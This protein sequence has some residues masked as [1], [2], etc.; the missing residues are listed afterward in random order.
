MNILFISKDLTG[1]DLAYRLK[2]EGHLVRLFIED[3]NQKQNLEGIVDKTN[4]WKKELKWVGKNGLIIFDSIGYGKTQDDL[5]KDGYSVLGGNQKSDQIE[6]D[7]QYGQKILSA[8]GISL[9]PSI[10]FS[11]VKEAIKFLKK[12]KGRWV[13]KQN[14]HVHKGF[15]YVGEMEDGSDT[16]EILKNYAK[17]NKKECSNIDLQKRVDGVEIGVARYFNGNDWVGPIEINME[18]KN[19]CNEDIGPKTDEMGTLMWYENNEKNKLFQK[20]LAKLKPYLQSINFKGDFDIDLIVNEDKIYPL[21]VTARLGW[22]AIQLQSEIHDSPWGE[23]L[24]AVADGK[25]YNLRY[26]KGF[27][28]VFLVATP[29][30]PYSEKLKKYS[31]Y[32]Q[33]IFFKNNFKKDDLKHIHLEEISVKKSRNNKEYYYISSRSGCILTVTSLG[34]TVSEARKKAYG[35][36]SK[37]VIPKAIYRTDIGLKFI[38]EHQNK[39]KK[40]GWI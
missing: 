17:N 40:W 4:D 32:G 39:L 21:E 31:L 22:P 1:G 36:I 29:P 26:K 37:V 38:E 11:N 13:V 23:F 12:N 34:K 14:G 9:V 6:H 27:G 2:Q 18:H 20:T 25:K 8:C 28:I 15:N 24:K 3:K 7:R 10:N 19:L 16:I 33:R 35:L 5:R 30:F